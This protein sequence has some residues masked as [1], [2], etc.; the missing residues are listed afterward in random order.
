MT[1]RRISS[2][3]RS[4]TCIDTSSGDNAVSILLRK[5]LPFLLPMC[6]LGAA[7][8]LSPLRQGQVDASAPLASSSTDSFG[9]ELPR[10]ACA[11]L[12]TVRLRQPE[13]I[14][15]LAWSPDGK[16]ILSA[17]GRGTVRS[18]DAATGEL[19]PVSIPQDGSHG[20]FFSRDGTLRVTASEGGEVCIVNRK[21]GK[22]RRP[23]L[24]SLHPC[25]ALSP[26]G[27]VLVGVALKNKLTIYDVEKDAVRFS[28]PTTRQSVPDVIAF[29]PDG[30][31]IATA[32]S[33][34]PGIVPLYLWDVGSGKQIGQFKGHRDQV[35][36]L[37][38]H[39]SDGTLVS[40]GADGT[41]R[42][43]N[44]STQKEVRQMDCLASEVCFSPD[45]KLLA[46][47]GA[48]D[49]VHFWNP[50]TGQ[51]VRSIVT[52][53]SRFY[54][55]AFSPSGKML[56]TGEQGGALRLWDVQTG[57]EVQPRQGHRAAILSLQFSL[58]GKK[59]ASLGG[60]QAIR[61]WDLATR[62]QTHCLSTK[63]TSNFSGGRLFCLPDG[64][65][66]AATGG[67]HI[68]GVPYPALLLWD[69]TNPRIPREVRGPNCGLGGGTVFS[70]DGQTLATVYSGGGWSGP[71]VG[72]YLWSLQTRQQRRMLPADCSQ[73]DF[74]P[75]GITL[76]GVN[77]QLGTDIKKGTLQ[78]NCQIVIW[79]WEA[80]K[81]LRQW[82]SPYYAPSIAFSPGGHLLAGGGGT[83]IKFS[84]DPTRPVYLWEP[85]SGS[86]VAT[87]AVPFTDRRQE[88]KALAFSPNGRLLAVAGTDGQ[89]RLW[90]VF[91]GK[92]LA[93]WPGHQGGVTCLA[94]SPDVRTLASGSQDTTILLWDVSRL[95]PSPPPG[96][97]NLRE[98]ASLASDLEG[99]DAARTYRAVWRLAVHGDRSV[100]VLRPALKPVPKLDAARIA[101]LVQQLND[102]DGLRRNDASAALE[103]MGPVVGPALRRALAGKQPPETQRRLRALIKRLG[104][105]RPELPTIA[106]SR[107]LLVLE[108]IG[109]PAALQR[110]KEAAEGEPGAALTRA[111]AM[112][113]HRLRRIDEPTR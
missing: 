102:D 93:A 46:S 41:I 42:I 15:W 17:S 91:N 26:D 39:P 18:W 19:V 61:L 57:R 28:I 56:A 58:D 6:W 9:N 86:L 81:V 38:Y 35:Y 88:I 16:T 111:A 82:S 2:L 107:A 48:R 113:L 3:L 63:T 72:V 52:A 13:S 55:I 103:K 59:L 8:L 90:D 12:G 7:L 32:R 105:E 40:S 24:R 36:S 33:R 98:L 25:V 49:W 45:G 31:Y 94:F 60:D 74:S 89:V 73:A 22:V 85:A 109:S 68:N 62:K 20:V 71:T 64:K 11:R 53:G 50:T 99:K 76:A 84:N 30:K 110:L 4:F 83:E 5:T 80:G 21:T 100:E 65:T 70:P 44:I 75:D 108:L 47:C 95:S 37:A 79:D 97:G 69:L 96:K 67:E 14:N 51:K 66:L 78:R 87:L 92:E 43:W 106:Q 77:I 29:S 34:L 23:W 10:H 27:K 104:V 112:T 101:R 54:A 1:A